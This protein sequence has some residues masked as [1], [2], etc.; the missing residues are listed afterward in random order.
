[1]TECESR[2]TGFVQDEAGDWI[3]E[4]DCGHRRH[5]RHN[6]PWRNSPWVVS[7]VGRRAM[8]GTAIPCRECQKN[9]SKS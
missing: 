7:E 5:V 3:A 9:I 4:L 1:M 6:P 8:L 2:I